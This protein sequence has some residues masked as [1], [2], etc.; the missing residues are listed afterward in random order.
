VQ[1]QTAQSGVAGTLATMTPAQIW[2]LFTDP[3]AGLFVTAVWSK[4]YYSSGSDYASWTFTWCGFCA[5]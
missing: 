1:L 4:S 3:I 5:T 2:P